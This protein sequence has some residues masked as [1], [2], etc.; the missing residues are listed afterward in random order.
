M[1]TLRD[2]NINLVV[3][4]KYDEDKM[5]KIK[6]RANYI[7]VFCSGHY[8]PH[9]ITFEYSDEPIVCSNYRF[10]LIGDGTYELIIG[11][12]KDLVGGYGYIICEYDKYNV[13]PRKITFNINDEPCSTLLVPT[14]S[15]FEGNFYIRKHYIEGMTMRDK[16]GEIVED[17]FTTVT[18]KW[19][20]ELI[21]FNEDVRFNKTK[22]ARK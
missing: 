21:M 12:R 6:T 13:L 7:S 16:S 8:L 19:G 15:E 2:K 20:D 5:N 18:N 9:P 1:V 4:E 17:I 3:N 22:S 14:Q 11:Y 10:K